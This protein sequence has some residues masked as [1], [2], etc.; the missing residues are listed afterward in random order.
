MH[1]YYS[2]NPHREK[3]ELLKILGSFPSWLSVPQF[4]VNR[5]LRL[6]GLESRAQELEYA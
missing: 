2:G 4:L 6:V 1:T 5:V 3:E